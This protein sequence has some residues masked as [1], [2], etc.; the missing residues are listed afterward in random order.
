MASMHTCS[1]RNSSALIC[2]SCC[3]FGVL[4]SI[5]L[6]TFYWRTTSNGVVTRSFK[7]WNPIT[8]QY[9]RE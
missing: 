8:R 4:C 7:L 5:T 1:S 2:A 3:I 9:D 6:F